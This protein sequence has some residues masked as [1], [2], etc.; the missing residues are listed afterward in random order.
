MPTLVSTGQFTIVDNNDAR[1]ITAMIA[2]SSGTQQIFTKD[3]STVSFLPD[4]VTSNLTLT[5]KL[6]IS[7]LTEAQVW[8]SLTSKTF[9]LTQGGAAV[10]SSTNPGPG[11][12][13]N[14]SNVAVAA[15]F[16]VTH[17]AAGSAAPST[18]KVKANLKDAVANQLI[19]F[20]ATYV[21]SLTGLTTPVVAQI[22]LSTV[23][24]GTNAVFITMRGQTNV[25][26]AT[27][28]SKN[29][30]CMAADLIR[31]SGIDIS[32][33][34][35]KW[36]DQTGAQISQVYNNTKYGMYTSAYPAIPLSSNAGATL[37]TGLPIAGA[38]NA[39]NTLVMDETAINNIGIYRVEI[40]DG[41]SK[42][43]TQYFTIYDISDE[44]KVTINS[45]TG[46][47]LQN[48]QGSTT[49]TPTVKYGATDVSVL[50]DYT[51][52]WRFYDRNGK[53]G[54]FI[55]TAKISTAGGAPITANSGLTGGT[56]TYTGT[57]Y[58]FTSGNVIKVVNA[59]GAA[60]FYEVASSVANVITTRAPSTN[61]AWLNL[62]NFPAPAASDFV[63]GK[64]Y[65]CHNTNN[66]G[67]QVTTT[68]PFTILLSGDEVD[69]KSMIA[70]DAA[71]P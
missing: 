62:T 26:Q 55:D 36:Y 24:T 34:S 10:I 49:L 41:D 2:S 51:F 37:N 35:Y 9:S 57:P 52:T 18:L 69:A 21:D 16:E 67:T 31:S 27:G 65:G 6:F 68:T 46:N 64:L 42:T 48:G 43:Y 60:S 8:A 38:G 56:F 13:V 23:K 53:Q 19:I 50:T 33:L 20:Q 70:C 30:I 11:N 14:N 3:E 47:L 45:S 61:S 28:S 4:Y 58:N 22:T 15:P 40:T 1:T 63:G 12:F 5:P 71:R 44:Y 54:A 25:E 32:Q 66:A 7:G 29:K 59:A 39:F 17:A